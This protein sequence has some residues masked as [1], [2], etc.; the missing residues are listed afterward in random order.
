MDETSKIVMRD[1]VFI[2]KPRFFPTKI[3][4]DFINLHN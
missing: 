1:V 4:K 2:Q 3:A